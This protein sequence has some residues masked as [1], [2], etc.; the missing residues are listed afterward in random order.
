MLFDR[1]VSTGQVAYKLWV[2]TSIDKKD[3]QYS[4]NQDDTDLTDLS[5]G[6]VSTAGN[7]NGCPPSFKLK[8][9][10]AAENITLL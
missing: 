10:M 7:T 8:A 5:L 9:K 1:D 2:K 3:I 4:T 6:F